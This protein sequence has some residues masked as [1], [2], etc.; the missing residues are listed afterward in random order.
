MILINAKFPVL[1]AKGPDLV[2]EQH[3]IIYIDA[4]Q[5]DG[6][7]PMGEIRPRP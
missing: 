7:G 2:A 3:Q 1:I 6:W 5:V 4:P